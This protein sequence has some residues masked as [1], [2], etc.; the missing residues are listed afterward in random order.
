MPR[1]HSQ[2]FTKRAIS[3]SPAAPGTRLGL[4]ESIATR[5]ASRLAVG[6]MPLVYQISV[7]ERQ[8]ICFLGSVV[9]G[10][11]HEIPIGVSGE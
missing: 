2:A 6:V 4:T 5:E 7:P 11:K 1:A 9:I 10:Q 8:G 3:I